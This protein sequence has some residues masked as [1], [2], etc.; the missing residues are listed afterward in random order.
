[1]A[2][3]VSGVLRI[4]VT[5][6]IAEGKSTVLGYLRDAGYDTISSDTVARELFETADL[7]EQLG[8]IAGLALPVSPAALR[9]AISN[10]PSIRREVNDLM[11]PAILARLKAS[12]APF[13]EV[14]LLIEAC[15]QYEFDRVWVVTCGSQEQRARLLAR[16]SDPEHVER[17]LRA[18]LPTTSKTPFSDFAVRTNAP[19][20]AVRR[21]VVEEA[22][23]V[24]GR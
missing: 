17:L 8:R 2:G 15:L 14:P 4:A 11:H 22:R 10:S 3:T 6:G 21:L 19:E 9:A 12:S 5:G 1:L 24:L 7:N 18:Q 23:L 16:Y 20:E 13:L